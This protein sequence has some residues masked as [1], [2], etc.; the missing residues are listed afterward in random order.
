MV[1]LTSGQS[2]VDTLNDVEEAGELAN[3]VRR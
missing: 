3:V 2:E 1:A